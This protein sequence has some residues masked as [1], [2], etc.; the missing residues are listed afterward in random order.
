MNVDGILQSFHHALART[1]HDLLIRS[2]PSFA[3]SLRL[4][5]LVSGK[6]LRHFDGSRYLMH[7]GG[8]E[9]TVDSA[10]PLRTG[11]I[12]HGRVIG[13][14]DKVHLQRV[15]LRSSDGDKPAL[16]ASRDEVGPNNSRSSALDELLAR[17]QVVLTAKERIDLMQLLKSSAKPGLMSLAG[18]ILTK[19]GLSLNP[20]LARAL[21]RAL[22]SSSGGRFAEVAEMAPR[23]V[24]EKAASATQN[25]AAVTQLAALLQDAV[26]IAER[27]RLWA[28]SRAGEESASLETPTRPGNGDDHPAASDPRGNAQARQE[29]QLGHFLL[30]AQSGGAVSHR[31]TSFPI[32]FGDRLVEV[33]LAL[34]SQRDESAKPGGI[35]HRR[36][37]IAIDTELFGHIEIAVQ[38]ANQNLRVEI[39]AENELTA[40]TLSRY[41]TEL[42]GALNEAGWQLDQ[43]DYAII[44]R[45][46]DSRVASSVVTHHISHD[47]L[48]RVM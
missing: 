26:R 15:Y 33:S 37:H 29:W 34:F 21:Y 43:I 45:D 31:L 3:G 42:K 39:G 19:I 41:L 48:N 18:L 11:E 5:E 10:V 17:H 24:A 44:E 47:S 1:G 9:R 46:E 22:D 20:N 25:Q 30:N 40:G 14:D 7:I 32:W 28:D 36:L 8:E 4:G 2:D 35:R 16:A 6:V 12:I 38:A 13:L 27:N 23:L